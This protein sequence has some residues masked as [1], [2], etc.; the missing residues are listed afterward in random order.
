MTRLA[1]L[2]MLMLFLTLRF[3]AAEV[4]CTINTAPKTIAGQFS[5]AQ[6]YE[7]GHCLTINKLKAVEHYTNAA[8]AGH[9][10]SQYHLAELY[11]TGYLPQFNAP[12]ETRI[13]PDYP[14]AKYWYMQAAQQGHG[15][16]QLRLAFLYAENHFQGLETDLDQA[17]KWF[18]KAAQQNAGDARFRLGNF[19]QHY[20]KPPQY[21]QAFHWL[22]Q[23]AEGQH[24]VAQ[25]DLANFYVQGKG[26]ITRDTEQWYYW[27]LK[28]A[29]QDN[30]HAQIALSKAHQ[31]GENN[32]P[33]NAQKSIAWAMR[34]ARRTKSALWYNRIGDAFYTGEGN[35]PKSIKK[36]KIWYAYSAEKGDQYAIDRLSEI[37]LAKDQD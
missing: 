25:H 29:K 14:R 33:K 35:M 11:F 21:D 31:Y 34:V 5:L 28:S 15:D 20:R 6:S 4:A 30:L 10:L 19:Y 7:T 36:A 26:G 1:C 32:L 27:M 13:P 9:M 22:K 2:L 18:L 24:R 37:H 3:A 23:A 12:E 8:R 16:A 17:E